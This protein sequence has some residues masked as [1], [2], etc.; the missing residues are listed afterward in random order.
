MAAEI[1]REGVGNDGDQLNS[2]RIHPVFPNEDIL[3]QPTVHGISIERLHFLIHEG[4]ID[5][6]HPVRH[7]VVWQKSDRMELINSIYHNYPLPPVI[8]MVVEKEDGLET[9]VCIVGNQHLISMQKFI[10]GQIPWHADKDPQTSQLWW[11][12]ASETMKNRRKIIP[13]EGKQRFTEKLITCVEYRNLT[14]EARNNV[15]QH[16]QTYCIESPVSTL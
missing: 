9:R 3:Q 16:F 1:K 7:G 13:P 8:F 11:Y 4:E 2:Q 12:T 6:D 14:D 5:I 10:D 15:L